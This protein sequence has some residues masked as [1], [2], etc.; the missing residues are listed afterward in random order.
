MNSVCHQCACNAAIQTLVSPA[1]ALSSSAHGESKSW[2]PHSEGPRENGFYGDSQWPLSD[3]LGRPSKGRVR[4][5]SHDQTTRPSAGRPQTWQGVACECT[6]DRKTQT[7]G[8]HRNA[9]AG[10]C[11]SSC[12]SCRGHKEGHPTRGRKQKRAMRLP[13]TLCICKMWVW[14]DTHLP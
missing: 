9:G 10:I 3:R 14:E 4:G 12:G 8:S 6:I 1:I 5:R 11:D 13:R 7:P 2:R